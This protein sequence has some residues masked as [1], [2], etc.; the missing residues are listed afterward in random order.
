MALNLS[1]AA[2]SILLYSMICGA[3][4]GIIYY[5]A[6]REPSS[7]FPP[8]PRGLP[9]LGNLLQIPSPD[10]EPWHTYCAW[11]REYNSDIIHLRALGMHIVVLNSVYLV[12]ELLE[13]RSSIYSDRPELVMFNELCGFRWLIGSLSSG[14]AWRERRKMAH[15]E[16]HSNATIKYRPHQHKVIHR[17]LLD[18]LRGPENYSL[19]TRLWAGGTILSVTY[20]IDVESHDNSYFVMAETASRFS[21]EQIATG[22]RLVDILPILKHL[23]D[24]FPGAGFK[25]EAGEVRAVADRM[26]NEPFEMVCRHMADGHVTPCAAQSL[27]E[28]C[29]ENPTGSKASDYDIRCA[30]GSMYFAGAETNLSALQTFFLAMVL[31]PDV[32]VK[33]H[34]EIDRV[35]GVHQLPDYCDQAALPYISAILKEVLRWRPVAPLALPHLTKT[36]DVYEGYSIPKGSL[37]LANTWYV[38]THAAPPLY[39]RCSSRSIL[40]DESAYNNPAQFNPSRFLN[41]DGTLNPSVRDPSVAAFGFGRRICPGRFLA[42][43]ALWLAIVSVLAVFDIVRAVDDEGQEIVPDGEYLSGVVCFP[44]P[45]KCA[46]RP[47]SVEHR[48]LVQLLNSEESPK[49]EINES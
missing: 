40:H 25:R 4:A 20:G 2:D 43:D 15:R 18:F 41:E 46:V 38:L 21:I 37:V 24:W 10:A 22:S 14:D 13:K 35:V 34:E 19:H 45:F 39:F 30:L 48:D 23:P 44:K 3:F 36:D 17:L 12:N 29:G 26:L 28:A 5:R 27:I 32:Q 9:L 16:F 31:H 7:L 49:S 6:R 11:S 33:A 42:L 47:R 8:G 1:T